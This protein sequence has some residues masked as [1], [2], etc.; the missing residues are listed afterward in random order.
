[1][2]KKAKNVT[3]NVTSSAATFTAP[4]GPEVTAPLCVGFQEETDGIHIQT[5]YNEDTGQVYWENGLDE[6]TDADETLIEN[7]LMWGELG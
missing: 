6:W 7:L 4:K 5:I 2:L 1:M 3:K